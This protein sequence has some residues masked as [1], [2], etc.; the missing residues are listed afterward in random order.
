MMGHRGQVTE[1]AK[2]KDGDVH[3]TTR[4]VRDRGQRRAGL[5]GWMP[6][7]AFAV[8][9][10]VVAISTGCRSSAPAAAPDAP[11]PAGSVPAPSEPSAAPPAPGAAPTSAAELADTWGIEVVGL[12][13]S[14]AGYMLDFRYKV[15][16]PVKAAP[17]FVRANKPV[18]V[19]HA[20]GA[21]MQIHSPAKTGPLRPTNPPQAGRTYFM[22][23]A[24]AQ[25]AVQ[26]G[27]VVTV[28][29]GPFA[30]DVVVE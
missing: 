18:A 11:A 20:T 23:F 4:A 8:A 12:R 1:C 21:R 10:I 7:A 26:A 29:I 28:E 13:R 24:N 15:L 27:D 19:H 16:D 6:G 9:V 2:G 30:A 5:A 17:L 3:V 25:G 22:F 14:A